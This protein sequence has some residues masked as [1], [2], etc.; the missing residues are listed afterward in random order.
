VILAAKPGI[1]G[2]K[3]VEA[4]AKTSNME[5]K[6]LRSLRLYEIRLSVMSRKGAKIAKKNE[7]QNFGGQDKNP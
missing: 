2:A 6:P 1:A 5:W 4:L 7:L 3:Q